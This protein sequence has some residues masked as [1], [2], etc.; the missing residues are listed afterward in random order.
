VINLIFKT[1]KPLSTV[2]GRT[3][4]NKKMNAGKLF[5]LNYLGRIVWKLSPKVQFFF[6]I[7]NYQAFQNKQVNLYEF[8]LLGTKFKLKSELS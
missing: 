8:F 2:S 3:V 4:K 6:Q 1:L 5:T 7:M